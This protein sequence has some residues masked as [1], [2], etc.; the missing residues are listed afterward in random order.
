MRLAIGRRRWVPGARLARRT[1]SPLLGGV[2]LR[3]VTWWRSPALDR[4]LAAGFDP[5]TSDE[6]SLRAGQLQSAK[7]RARLAYGLRG[8]VNLSGHPVNPLVLSSCPIRRSE[9]QANKDLILEL[10]ERVTAM[11]V[12]TEGLARTS[13]LI[14]DGSSP[15]YRGSKGPPLRVAAFEALLALERGHAHQP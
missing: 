11:P 14:V 15:M 10:A 2:W 8:A 13:V 9:V 3:L 1:G 4:E 7:S 5:L 12:S 6:L